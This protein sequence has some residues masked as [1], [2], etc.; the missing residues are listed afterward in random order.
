MESLVAAMVVTHNSQA[1]IQQTI[2]SIS[3]QSKAPMALVVIDDHSAD[4]TI[5][6][7]RAQTSDSNFPLVIQPSKSTSKD[8]TTRIAMN[9]IQGVQAAADLGAD[10]VAL[11]DHDDIWRPD[12]L[13]RQS[14]LLD[15]TPHALMVASDGI[16]LGADGTLRGV[17][18][19][20]P[21]WPRV[22]PSDQLRYALRHSLA[23]G[24]ASM[25]RPRTFAGG[26]EVPKGW[27]HDRWWSLVAVAREGMLLD[28]GFAIDYR[29]QEGQQVGLDTGSQQSSTKIRA[30]GAI[31]RPFASMRKVRDLHEHLKPQAKTSALRSELRWGAI[32]GTHLQ[33]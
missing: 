23:T 4:N 24:G 27:L 25:I 7:I 16:L 28:D 1:W 3:L 31:G 10:L 26:L 6:L 15:Q 12:R 32:L 13:E 20:P 11:G 21:N 22:K 9:F 5:G 2:A 18:P 14:A 19:V 30:K 33:R 17:F 8:I 29:V